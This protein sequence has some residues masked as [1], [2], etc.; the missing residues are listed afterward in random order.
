MDRVR[1]FRGP[2]HGELDLMRRIDEL[3]LEF[4][5]SN[6]T[7]LRFDLTSVYHLLEHIAGQM[8]L[9]DLRLPLAT[10]GYG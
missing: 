6:S 8:E 1:S 2:V 3:H 4:P 5:I 7:K 9:G 10:P